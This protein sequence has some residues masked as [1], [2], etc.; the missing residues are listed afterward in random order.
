MEKYT[1]L[2]SQFPNNDVNTTNL[3]EEIRSTA[4]IT[5]SLDH[6]NTTSDYCDIWFRAELTQPEHAT[7]SGVVAAHEGGDSDLVTNVNVM[8]ALALA[9]TNRSGKI[10]VHE[11]S[12]VIGTTTY[13]TGAGDDPSNPIDIG[14]GTKFVLHHRIGDPNPQY[15]YLDFNCVEN[16]T[17]IHEGYMIWQSAN[18]DTITFE[19]VPRVVNVTSGTNTYYNLY[20]GYLVI[21]AAGDGTIE[22]LS[23]ITEHDGGLVYIPLDEE[24]N[25]TTP[26][27]WN[28]DWNSTTKKYEN[29]T[30]APLGNG[31]F[32]MFTVE[33]PLHRFV[34]KIPMLGEGFE[35]T[36]TADADEIGHGMRLRTTMITNDPDHYWS[37]GCILTLHREKTVS[38]E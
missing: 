37:V 26:C 3:T 2:I 27:F 33:V 14:G 19:I 17:W 35:R 22:L 21:P 8:N 15:L 11:S 23:D 12:R 38:G 24:G 25:R 28:A 20:G 31:S 34:N 9:A 13:F 36:Q 18:F 16:E 5:V 30:A 1:Y 6:I 7:L 4:T 10:E 32:N 29:I